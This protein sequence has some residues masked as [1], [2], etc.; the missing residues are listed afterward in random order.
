MKHFIGTAVILY[1]ALALPNAEADSPDPLFQEDAALRVEITA[2]FARLIDERP[3][4]EEFQGSFSFKGPDDSWVEGCVS[5]RVRFGQ[6][7]AS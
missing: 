4:E 3:K 7:K 5:S 6:R 2:P 1:M